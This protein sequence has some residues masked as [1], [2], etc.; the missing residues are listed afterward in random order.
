M[1][2]PKK[3]DVITFSGNGEPTLHPDFAGIIDDTIAVRNEYAPNAKV[4]VLSNATNLL[5]PAVFAAL[6]KVDNPI[7]KLDSAIIETL[8]RINL[9]V[10]NISIAD[11][12]SG[13]QQFNGNFILQTMFLRG[14]HNGKS[15]DNT[16]E[17]EL[18]ALLACL[19]AT[20][21]RQ[22]MIYPIDRDTPADSLV[23]LSQSE[24]QAIAATISEA[25]FNVLYV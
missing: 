16:T 22:V 23:K 19:E 4:S 15:I 11:I 2:E 8:N 10:H 24:M 5:K 7:L 14:E 25:G 6:Q 12:I 18:K 17:T 1:D 20:H 3:L 21:P 9:P 13:M